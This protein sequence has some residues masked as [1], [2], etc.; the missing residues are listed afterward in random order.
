MFH[1][2]LCLQQ[3]NMKRQPCFFS[4][5]KTGNK[6][7]NNI[8]QI[9]VFM[10]YL[11]SGS[12]AFLHKKEDVDNTK[13]KI[14]NWEI[15]VMSREAKRGRQEQEDLWNGSRR[16]KEVGIEKKSKAW[17][18]DQIPC[19]SATAFEAA[20]HVS[21]VFDE[22]RTTNDSYPV[23]TFLLPTLT[24]KNKRARIFTLSLSWSERPRLGI[25]T[26]KTT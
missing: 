13:W 23:F 11:S 4:T 25:K 19:D 20:C 12:I 22:N 6:G 3:R 16:K 2:L 9:H 15:Q 21:R 18:C 26:S 17:G 10:L 1:W 8:W 5:A 14:Q 7:S 24:D